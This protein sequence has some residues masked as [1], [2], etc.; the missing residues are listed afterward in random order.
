VKANKNFLVYCLLGV[1]KMLYENAKC[2][3]LDELDAIMSSCDASFLDEISEEIVVLAQ[4]SLRNRCLS[5]RAGC[6][7]I[8]CLLWYLEIA[9]AN[10]YFLCFEIGGGCWRRWITTCW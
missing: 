1:P 3:H 9:Y 5:Y 8:C 10:F 6:E 2:C 4:F 7:N